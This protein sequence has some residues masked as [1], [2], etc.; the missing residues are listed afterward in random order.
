KARVM[1]PLNLNQKRLTLAKL[2]HDRAK[3]TEKLADLRHDRDVMTIHA[4]T[5]GLVYYGQCDRGRWTTAA[6]MAAKLRKGGN[7]LPDEVLITIV[8][9]RP[10]ALR[11]SVDEK[12]LAALTQRAEL[13][14]VVTP[15][16]DPDRRLPGRLASIASVPR[17]PGKFEAVIAVEPGEDLA[18]LKPGMAGTI[19][20]VPYR[21]DDALTAPSTAVFD[22]DLPR[23]P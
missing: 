22:H 4:P 15:A 18:A 13:K 5:D 6:A 14:G 1:L 19:K 7:L 10:L 17:E 2:E 9:P 8:A 3:G 23:T 16:F 20:F 11:A 12:D 21:T